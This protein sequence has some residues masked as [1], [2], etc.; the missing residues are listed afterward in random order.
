MG[1]HYDFNK[2]DKTYTLTKSLNEISG[3]HAINNSRVFCIEDEH[4]NIH[5]FNFK[6]HKVVKIFGKNKKGD[7]EDIVVIDKTAYLLLAHLPAIYIYNNFKYSMTIAYKVKLNLDKKYDPVGMCYHRDSGCLIIA[8]KGDPVSGSTKRKVFA[9]D[10]QKKKRLKKPFLTIDA[11]KFKAYKPGKTFNPSGIAIHPK[12][13]EIYLLGSKSL[14]MII[15]LDKNGGK[16]LEE[17]KLK[18]K[19]YSQPEG[20]SFLSNGDLLL[21]TEKNKTNQARLFKICK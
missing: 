10:I 7:V 9:F 5:E 14:K 18:D 20:I 16:V 6:K 8:C 1:L 15:R 2:P 3:I 19:I 21:T 11:K 17:Y 13:D 4:L 12:T